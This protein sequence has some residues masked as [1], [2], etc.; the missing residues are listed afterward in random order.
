MTTEITPHRT[1]C[2]LDSPIGKL[3]LVAS[4]G[5]LAGVYMRQHRHQPPEETF[6]EY[7][8]ESFGEV[9]K[10]LT[11]YFAG[12]RTEFDLPLAMAGTPFQRTVWAALREIPFGETMSYGGLADR[13]GRPGASRAVGL[14]NGRNPVSIIVP[15]HRVV[16]S[17][18]DLTGYGGGIE[19]KR[20][21]LAFEKA[22]SGKGFAEAAAG[23]GDPRL[24]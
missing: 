4:D 3:T 7:D 9:R 23:E 24:F 12:E 1:H 14:A 5:V 22:G 15:C 6:G 21:L 18:G 17:T 13:I 2:V 19:R 11:E 10:Q 20:A 8:D 16:G